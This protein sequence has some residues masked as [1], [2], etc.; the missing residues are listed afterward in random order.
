MKAV[1]VNSMNDT[2]SAR[3]VDML[4][5]G[6]GLGYVECRCD[7]EDSHGWR[8]LSSPVLGFADADAA[9]AA[10]RHEVGWLGDNA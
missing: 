2:S 4:S 9:T 6:N 1:V 7:P 10:A 8:R 3:C 5:D